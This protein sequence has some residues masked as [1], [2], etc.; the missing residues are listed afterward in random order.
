MKFY[1]NTKFDTY[2]SRKGTDTYMK[3]SCDTEINGMFSV[4]VIKETGRCAVQSFPDTTSEHLF[5]L[6]STNHYTE[7]E[8]FTNVFPGLDQQSRDAF[9]IAFK[10]FSRAFKNHLTKYD[11]DTMKQADIYRGIRELNKRY[12]DALVGVTAATVNTFNNRVAE[13]VFREVEAEWKNIDDIVGSIQPEILNEITGKLMNDVGFV[14]VDGKDY[15]VFEDNTGKCRLQY[16]E[17]I[18]AANTNTNTNSV[19]GVV[20]K[21]RESRKMAFMEN[22]EGLTEFANGRFYQIKG[23]EGEFVSL[24]SE[25]GDVREIL[26]NRVSVIN[27][28]TEAPA[29]EENKEQETVEA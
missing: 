12:N 23:S 1:F 27:V 10:Q 29:E 18:S 2:A 26:R 4:F 21:V 24:V 16:R 20:E 25:T 14:T 8:F 28:F 13:K 19:A 9:T 5:G 15:R 22:A 6:T 17:S 7:E 3:I 11:M